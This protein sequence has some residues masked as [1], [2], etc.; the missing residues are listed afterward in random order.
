VKMIRRTLR[1]RKVFPRNG[2][3]CAL[4]NDVSEGMPFRILDR[5][6]V[7]LACVRGYVSQDD[8]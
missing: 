2:T 8:A 7:V 3:Y 4:L 6:T 1:K 5:R